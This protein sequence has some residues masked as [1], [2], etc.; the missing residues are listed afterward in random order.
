MLEQV[1]QSNGEGDRD[2]VFV[3]ARVAFLLSISRRAFLRR[4]IRWTL[5]SAGFSGSSLGSRLLSRES[6]LVSDHSLSAS[7]STLLSL[8]LSPASS[9]CSSSLNTLFLGIGPRSGLGHRPC[10]I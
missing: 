2:L 6:I 1:I 7:L 4:G 5:G 9:P 3:N 8:P 10:A